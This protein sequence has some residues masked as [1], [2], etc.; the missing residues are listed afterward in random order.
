ML[1]RTYIHFMSDTQK[2]PQPLLA[3]NE[4]CKKTI[5]NNLWCV[6]TYDRRR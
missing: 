1:S 2:Q 4:V 3:I 6:D 5:L